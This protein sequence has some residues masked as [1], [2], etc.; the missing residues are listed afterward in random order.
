MDIKDFADKK[1]LS[2][3]ERNQLIEELRKDPKGFLEDCFIDELPLPLLKVIENEGLK[4]AEIAYTLCQKWNADEVNG[5]NEDIDCEQKEEFWFIKA[6]ELNS[7]EVYS[8]DFIYTNNEGEY[9]FYP[10]DICRTDP[11]LKK[12][13]DDC[14][15]SWGCRFALGLDGYEINYRYACRAYE[16]SDSPNAK[17]SLYNIYSKGLG[18]KK[19]LP[20]AFS[21]IKDISPK[22]AFYAFKSNLSEG[23]KIKRPKKKDRIKYNLINKATSMFYK[24]IGFVFV[25]GLIGGFIYGCS[26]LF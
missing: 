6:C 11:I 16:L 14:F 1:K 13:E 9:E 21:Y 18:V 4:D 15:N 26:K 8:E 17:I 3:E 24:F 23:T 22:T 7:V 20:K 19:N 10:F 25:V 5:K 12:A 2:V